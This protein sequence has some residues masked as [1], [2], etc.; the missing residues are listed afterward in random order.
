MLWLKIGD[1]SGKIYQY[2]G[3]YLFDA[4]VVKLEQLLS[5][6]DFVKN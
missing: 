5:N 6:F 1:Y 2:L 4:K 3:I